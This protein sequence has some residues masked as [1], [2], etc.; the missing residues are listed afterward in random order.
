MRINTPSVL[1]QPK[2]PMRDAITRDRVRQ[3]YKANQATLTVMISVITNISIIYLSISAMAPKTIEVQVDE[4]QL[5]DRRSCK[6]IC[7]DSIDF[8]SSNSTNR[9]FFSRICYNSDRYFR[10]MNLS[11]GNY[12]TTFSSP[13]QCMSD[14]TEI[15]ST[16]T[17]GSS[18]VLF[19]MVSGSGN[20]RLYSGISGLE[21]NYIINLD[22]L[23]RQSLTYVDKSRTVSITV[24]GDQISE[25][26][27]LSIDEVFYLVMKA[28]GVD[29]ARPYNCKSSDLSQ[30]AII[31]IGFFSLMVSLFSTI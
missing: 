13:H 8:Y 24:V 12:S 1:D 23:E 10:A 16:N 31:V 11:F 27:P 7:I 29:S 30:I 20:C 22:P 25:E 2:A 14:I 4:T 9:Q 17:S 19:K 5:A 15:P 28:Y 18:E 26:H 21:S 3:M 6:A